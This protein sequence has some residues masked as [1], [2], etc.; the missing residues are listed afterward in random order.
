[1]MNNHFPPDSRLVT[2]DEARSSFLVSRRAF[3]DPEILRL[4]HER[5]FDKCWLYIGHNSEIAK[6]GDFVKRKVG[7]RDLIFNRDASGKAHA[8]YN[9]CPHRGGRI[10]REAAGNATS[11]Q[12]MYHGWVFSNNGGLRHLPQEEVYPP[13]FVERMKP[14]LRP[15]PRLDQYRDFWFVCFDP[16]VMSLSDYLAGAKEYLDRIADQSAIGMVVVP[17][18]QEFSV[19]SN[20]KLW[21]ENIVDPFHVPSLHASWFDFT[22]ETMAEAKRKNPNLDLSNHPLNKQAPEKHERDRYNEAKRRD[23]Q[24]ARDPTDELWKE[25]S[26]SNLGNGHLGYV[27]NPTSGRPF[28]YWHP[29]WGEEIKPVIDDVYAKTVAR[30]G[31]ER[32]HLIA[33]QHAHVAIFPNLSIVDNYGIMIR[34]YFPETPES[35]VVNSWT[36]APQEEPRELRRIRLSN[37]L[38]FLGPAGFGTPDDIEGL[39]QAQIGYAVRDFDGVNNL[40]AG[41]TPKNPAAIAHHGDDSMLRVFWSKWYD[42]LAIANENRTYDHLHRPLGV[43][44]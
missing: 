11:F 19:R 2:R 17:A 18:G 33:H 5:I 23:A 9:V 8:F 36:L 1:M 32:A 38:E 4:E 41:M 13:G 29:I 28:A 25:T 26:S 10:C 34:T 20:W 39:A 35:S 27:Y 21:H 3:V 14:A 42:Q 22:Y 16:A 15:V 37:Y 7:G 12:C 24:V 30:V 44:A 6:P 31:E 43:D 40:C